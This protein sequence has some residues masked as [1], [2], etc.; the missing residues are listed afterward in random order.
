MMAR[1]R[2]GGLV[3][4]AGDRDEVEVLGADLLLIE[5]L[6]ADP[7]HHPVPIVLAIQDDWEVVDLAG[8]DQGQRLVQ[9]VERAEAA[10]EDHEALGVL[11]KHDF[12]HEEVAELQAEVDELV[13]ALLE[14][15]LDVAADRDAASLLRPAVRRLHD[16]WAAAGDDREPFLDQ[17][18]REPTRGAVVAVAPADAS[19]AE[20]ADRRADRPASDDDGAPAMLRLLFPAW[21]GTSRARHCRYP[22]LGWPLAGTPPASHEPCLPRSRIGT[23]SIAGPAATSRRTDR[24][25]RRGHRAPRAPHRPIRPPRGACRS[26]APA[27]QAR[28]RGDLDAV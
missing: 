24:H 9:L 2:L 3:D 5:R 11:H 14:G 22:M 23:N 25:E 12:A 6:V 18:S 21:H 26:R 4:V 13:Q 1:D 16:A 20:D 10:G 17:R 27:G 19:R 28:R 15:K 8:L 7:A